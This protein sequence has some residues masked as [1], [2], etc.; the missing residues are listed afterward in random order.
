M[1]WK[2]SG[3]EGGDS[4][5]VFPKRV[6]CL[7]VWDMFHIGHLNLIQRASNFGILTVGV[8]EDK[9]VKKQKG[10]DRPL[11]NQ[12][13]RAS[14]VYGLKGVKDIKFVKDF[15]IPEDILNTY[16]L[17]V[18]GQDQSHIK[19]LKSIPKKKKIILDRTPSVS[20]SDIV[21]KLKG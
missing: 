6:F 12:M 15:I 2:D 7:G 14:I 16:D 17:I 1:G 21:K 20:T 19:N 9:A 5:P 11:I 10:K 8:V 3:E 13:D 18:I 4:K